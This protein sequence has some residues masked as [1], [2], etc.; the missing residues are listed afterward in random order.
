MRKNIPTPTE[1]QILTALW[2]RQTATVPELHAEICRTKEVAY[3]TVL[4]RVQ[5]MEEKGFLERTKSTGRAISYRALFKPKSTR[6]TLVNRLITMAFDDSPNALIQH[7][8]GQNKLSQEDIDEIRSLLDKVEN[9]D[10][11]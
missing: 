11:G 10:L 1:T 9:K 6:E 8:I 2:E 5:R 4:K 3:T 7:A